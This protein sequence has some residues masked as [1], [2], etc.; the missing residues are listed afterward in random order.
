MKDFINSYIE[1]LTLDTL[2]GRDILDLLIIRLTCEFLFDLS[3]FNSKQISI[4]KAMLKKA[5]STH[6]ENLG[7]RLFFAKASVFLL[8]GAKQLED[9]IELFQEYNLSLP[10]DYIS[11]LDC[12]V[13][14]HKLVYNTDEGFTLQDVDGRT[15]EVGPPTE[16]DRDK[17]LL[18]S[19]YGEM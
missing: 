15:V 3:K 13:E 14:G 7:N 17:H 8:E 11:R 2:E 5:V 4:I 1:R 19:I 6:Y 18:H 16:E 10:L 9:F 12:T